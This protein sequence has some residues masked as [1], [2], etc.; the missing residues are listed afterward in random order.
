MESCAWIDCLGRH[1]TI[2]HLGKKEILN[3]VPKN[4]DSINNLETMLNKKQ[5]FIKITNENVKRIINSKD[6]SNEDS[7]RFIYKNENDILPIPVVSNT[8]PL[9]TQQFLTHVILSLGNYD[10]ET[11]AL[12]HSSFRDCLYNGDL[13]GNN[14]DQSSLKT[15]SKNLQN[16]TLNNSCFFSELTLKIRKLYCHGQRHF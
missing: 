6:L 5:R 15:Y 1:L 13:I 14:T 3:I 8:S 12:C 7:T 16:Y 9:N 2:R 10:T 11:D 4:L